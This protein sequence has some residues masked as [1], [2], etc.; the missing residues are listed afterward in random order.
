MI[1]EIH[2]DGPTTARAASSTTRPGRA[3]TSEVS[4]ADALSNQPR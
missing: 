2:T 1:I 4:H 3:M